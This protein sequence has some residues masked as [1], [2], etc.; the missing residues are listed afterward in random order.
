LNS[1]LSKEGTQMD[2]RYMK[3]YSTL[4]RIREFRE[5]QIKTTV[6]CHFTHFI[7]KKKKDKSSED[8]D[9]GNSYTLL[10]FSSMKT[11]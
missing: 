8:V 3:R 2:N 1:P 6:K 7:K 10:V 5:I 9:K 4:P 11:V